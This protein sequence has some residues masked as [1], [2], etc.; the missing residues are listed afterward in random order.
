MPVFQGKNNQ[1]LVI[2]S[3]P[4]SKILF[5]FPP[6][7]FTTDHISPHHLPATTLALRH[8][9][10]PFDQKLPRNPSLNR[11]SSNQQTPPTTEHL[12]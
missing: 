11:L 5:L 7:P 12:V 9:G 3:R 10:H 2:S 4:R 6:P 8:L 1:R